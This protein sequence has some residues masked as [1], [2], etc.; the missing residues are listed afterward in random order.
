MDILEL[1]R[2]RKAAQTETCAPFAAALYDA[3]AE[4]WSEN[5]SRWP[6]TQPTVQT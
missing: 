2:T 6:V 4:K 5:I 3:L 1:I